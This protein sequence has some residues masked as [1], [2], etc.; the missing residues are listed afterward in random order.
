MSQHTWRAVSTAVIHRAAVQLARHV[1]S[2][3]TE[4]DDHD[5]EPDEA[6]EN[7]SE[8]GIEEAMAIEE[9]E[10]QTFNDDDE[11]ATEVWAGRVDDDAVLGNNPQRPDC[12]A[13]NFHPPLIA[14]SSP[15]PPVPT[16]LMDEDP[17]EMGP[18]EDNQ[19]QS[20]C[21]G[22]TALSSAVAAEGMELES[23]AAVSEQPGM[24][25][26]GETFRVTAHL[27][28]PFNSEAA[29]GT[30]RLVYQDAD[31][32][33]GCRIYVREAGPPGDDDDVCYQ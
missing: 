17:K 3:P 7:N 22:G 33:T 4:R 20:S 32:E 28:A 16:M 1:P 18:G 14:M 13:T 26:A 27:A 9:G 29:P 31:P 2:A 25:E 21:Q 12:N 5:E 15:S 19:A 11:M 23:L 24:H 10:D 6:P 8:G 30:R